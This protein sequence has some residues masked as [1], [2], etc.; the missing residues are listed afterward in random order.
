MSGRHGYMQIE[1][2]RM[3]TK[4]LSPVHQDTKWAVGHFPPNLPNLPFAKDVT[5]R[6]ARRRPWVAAP[7]YLSK[8]PP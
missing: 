1:M 2:A 7:R 6:S 4:Y 8:F 3:L 5:R